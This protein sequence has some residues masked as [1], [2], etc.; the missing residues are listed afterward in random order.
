MN[1]RCPRDSSR[2]TFHSTSGDPPSRERPHR[3]FRG[4]HRQSLLSDDLTDE[5][6]F[7][8]RHADDSKDGQLI[9]GPM[10][11]VRDSQRGALPI[12][13]QVAKESLHGEG[14]ISML[15]GLMSWWKGKFFILI[16]PVFVTTDFIITL[17][18]AALLRTLSKTPLCTACSAAFARARLTSGLHSRLLLFFLA[19]S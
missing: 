1:T 3:D 2:S 16:L 19:F 18:A 6:T 11:A 10:T 13:R 9:F 14:S 12:Y 4:R 7:G 15:A 8:D 17:S 5:H